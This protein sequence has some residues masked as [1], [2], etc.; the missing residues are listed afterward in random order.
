MIS[1]YGLKDKIRLLGHREDIAELCIAA[2]C[3][4]HPS[5]REGLGIA[6]LEGMAC[7]L[8][9]ISS[10]VN[11]I[12]DY[13]KDGISG[14]CVNPLNLNDMIYAIDKMYSNQE[15][16]K[17][18]SSH[19]LETVKTFDLEKSKEAMRKIYEKYI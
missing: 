3:F 18:C 17:K 13:T 10:F 4:V 1:Q 15:F 7:G 5:V 16:R 2:D 6:P 8:P 11:G 19:N 14:C 12:K 9:L